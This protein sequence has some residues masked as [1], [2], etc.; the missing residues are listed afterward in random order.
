MLAWPGPHHNERLSALPP[1]FYRCFTFR[2]LTFGL[3]TFR[4]LQ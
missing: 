2:L 1:L 3:S 4:P